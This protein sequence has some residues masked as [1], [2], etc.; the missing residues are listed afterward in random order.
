M[1]SCTSRS[2]VFATACAAIDFAQQTADQPQWQ[3]A[4]GGKKAFDVVSIRPSKPGTFTPASFPLDAWDAYRST[5]GRFEADFGLSTYIK[6]AYKLSLTTDQIDSMVAPLPK[7]VATDRF[8]IQAR[9]QGNPSKDQMR[10]MVQSMLADRFKLA[11]HF[12]NREVPLLALT[13][14]KHGKIGPKL[15]PHSAGPPCNVGDVFPPACDVYQLEEPPSGSRLAGSRNT[16]MEL[17]AGALPSLA[18]LARPVAD[19]T[20]L[21]GKFDFTIEWT[22]EPSEPPQPNSD[23]QGPTFLQALH[24]QLGLKL[25]STKGPLRTIVIDH[26]E[27]PSEN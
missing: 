5:G 13:L 25:Q 3:V 14:V 24:D 23:P 10:L 1:T 9:A 12:E 8:H 4:A 20:G 16:T 11:V 15:R 27:R 2:V 21:I 18:H 19:K 22:P 17:I 26:V 7:W 6:F